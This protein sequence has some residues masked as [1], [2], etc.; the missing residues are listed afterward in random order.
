MKIG[1]STS[2]GI[3]LGKRKIRLR[4]ALKDG[5]EGLILNLQ[6]V[7]YLPN[8]SC[9]LLSLGLLNNSDIYYDNENETL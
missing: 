3:S 8:S 7:F 4:V 6:N 1:G 9:N 2:D 5:F